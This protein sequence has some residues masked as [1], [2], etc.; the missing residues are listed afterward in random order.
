M[1][2]LQLLQALAAY[3]FTAKLSDLKGWTLGVDASCF[4]HASAVRVE[5][6]RDGGMLN[7]TFRYLDSA[8]AFMKA[9]V[10]Q[11]AKLFFVFDGTLAPSKDR[12][13]A[14]RALRRQLAR[15]QLDNPLLDPP[16]TAKQRKRLLKKSITVEPEMAWQLAKL[17]EAYG[18]QVIWALYEADPQ[19]A[20]LARSGQVD[21]VVT[22]DSDLI[23]FGTPHVLLKPRH[24]KQDV[25]FDSI[26]LNDIL[27]LPATN[28][29][30][31]RKK[32][33]NP[34]SKT[35]HPLDFSGWPF[36]KL[37]AFCLLI[38][39]D[40]LPRVPGVGPATAHQLITSVSNN[41]AD[42]LRRV[43]TARLWHQLR[44]MS[45]TLPVNYPEQY[46][47]AHAAFLFPLV[48]D[49]VQRI[50]TSLRPLIV[51]L[52]QNMQDFIGRCVPHNI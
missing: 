25:L 39:C 19:L 50:Q 1:G 27:G 51:E 40:Y 37:V 7:P 3:I 23:A 22:Q 46:T 43:E 2:V 49:P 52:P 28:S 41:P 36:E 20:Y 45:P 8:E 33:Q 10:R 6:E 16:L 34:A 9:C 38:G 47:Y 26:Q 4:L 17:A 14:Q 30:K 44:E 29:C 48:Y 15:A 32:V 13:N 24:A 42:P 21:A 5:V 11:G 12:V 18:F 35:P 31:R